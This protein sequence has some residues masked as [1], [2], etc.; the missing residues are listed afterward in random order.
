[1]GGLNQPPPPV[2]VLPSSM[3]WEVGLNKIECL[4]LLKLLSL[5]GPLNF[6]NLGLRKSQL[7][8]LNIKWQ[9]LG[10][11]TYTLLEGGLKKFPSVF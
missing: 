3:P 11:I 9:G 8:K 10:L 5:S 2:R 7:G 1:M 4:L 6:E